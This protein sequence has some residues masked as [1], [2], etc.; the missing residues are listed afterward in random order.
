MGD[1]GG[2]TLQK[3]QEGREESLDRRA[4]WF[5]REP[6]ILMAIICIPHKDL[7][8]PF[9]LFSFSEARLLLGLA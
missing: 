2:H 3:L 1:L 6:C 5:P 4:Q 9:L 8:P 7:V